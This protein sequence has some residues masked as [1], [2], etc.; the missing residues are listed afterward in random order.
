M[1]ARREVI[2]AVNQVS[3]TRT[4]FVGAVRVTAKIERR[5]FGA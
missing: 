2:I 4:R 3:R 5:F 1:K